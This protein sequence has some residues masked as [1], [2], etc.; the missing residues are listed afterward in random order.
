MKHKL[1]PRWWGDRRHKIFTV[2]V[3]IILAS[4][5]NAARTVFPPLYA[6]MARSFSVTE[7]RLG[8]VT[9]QSIL[10]MAVTAVLWGYWGDR[11]SRKRLLIYGTL[12]WS[13]A[14]FLTGMA[15]TYSQLLLFQLITAVGIGSIV[16]VGF[17]V[18]ADFIPPH[19]RGL[20]MSLWG[21]SQGGG[22]G[23]GALLGSLLGAH[24][25]RL[26]FFVIA[27]AGLV[28]V[29]LYLFT[30][31]P[32]RGRAEPAL[33]K[34]FASGGQYE[35]RIKLADIRYIL[36]RRSN[37]WLILQGFTA[38]LAFGSLIWRS[39][40][41][42]ARLETAG[43]SLETATMV[44]NMLSL[45]FETGFYFAIV[46]GYLGDRW[47]RRNPRARAWIC[48]IGI[49]SA[50][51]FHVALFFIPLPGLTIPDQGGLG[52]I[53]LAT[54]ASMFTN[55]WVATAFLL[56]LLAT[57]LAVID[58]P[59]RAAL[60]SDVNL[61]EHRGTMAGLV[62]L[63]SGIGLAIGN[64]LAGVTFSYLG[65]RFASP[66]NFATG[67]ALFQLFFIPAGLFYYQ[68]T[69]T[70]PGDIAAVRQALVERAKSKIAVSS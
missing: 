61:P 62:T 56:A 23:G 32:Q 8:L 35:H 50:I 3:F 47:Q 57:A 19:R 20:M 33:S 41:F 53:V 60:I 25:W 9:A 48:T 65:S 45:L 70:T 58:G 28:F 1:R 52:P 43:Y 44:G 11:S 54:L 36:G 21:L 67:L 24:N 12:I 7:A 55:G 69:K 22:G 5:D 6:I 15:Q 13:A 14:M 39:R 30:Y 59:N 49:L 38:T 63:A 2:V 27:G 18:A 64:A 37:V 34:L 26:P 66:L 68:A 29:I 4:L 51:P 17:S 40:L 10:V 46:G 42:I 16:S 31:E